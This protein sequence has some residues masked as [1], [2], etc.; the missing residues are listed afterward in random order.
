MYIYIYIL[1][2]DKNK[3]LILLKEVKKCFEENNI[4]DRYIEAEILLIQTICEKKEVDITYSKIK[5]AYE[6]FNG[7]TSKI[8]GPGM[9]F[10]F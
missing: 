2:I 7:E 3:G 5:K 4:L 1:Q 10:T 9:P 6:L 8:V